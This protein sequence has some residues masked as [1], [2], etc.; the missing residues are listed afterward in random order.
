VNNEEFYLLMS[1]CDFGL[2]FKNWF[3]FVS[4]TGLTKNPVQK[5]EMLRNK[6]K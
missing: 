1:S 4:S 3:I 5:L 2:D 6:N